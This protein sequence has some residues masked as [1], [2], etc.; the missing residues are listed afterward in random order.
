[1]VRVFV[2]PWSGRGAARAL[3]EQWSAFEPTV[4]DFEH[5]RAQILSRV[6]PGAVVVVA[7]GDG[8]ASSV[9]QCLFEAG[10]AQT[11]RL[12]IYPV[13]TG[14]DLARSLCCVRAPE[15]GS[16]MQ[17]LHAEELAYRPV[18][19]WRIGSRY[20]V[21]Y[22]G[23]GLEA[24][25]LAMA[26]R[27]RPRFRTRPVLR[28][29]SLAVAGF[30]HTGYRTR[31]ESWVRTDSGSIRIGETRGVIFSN[32][33]YYGGGRPIGAQNPSEPLLSVTVLR[34]NTD[35]FRL[36]LAYGRDEP[37]L[38]YTSTREATLEGTLDSGQIDGEVATLT[39]CSITYAGSILMGCLQGPPG[40]P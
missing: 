7:G 22:L 33:G 24:S 35:L 3:I 17:A 8:S 9:V 4:I 25:I 32:V 5:L 20:A 13:G 2:N 21:N 18:A 38:A 12:A 19:V 40:R 31:G 1:M 39:S 34:R 26:D 36:M 37:P 23:I 29:L 10:L 30:L 27:W 6:R 16:F 14:N 15:P 11:V 28:K